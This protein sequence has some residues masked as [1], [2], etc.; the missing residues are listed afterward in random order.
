MVEG[1]Q[2]EGSTP[3]GSTTRG[4]FSPLDAVRLASFKSGMK[5]ILVALA[6]TILGA[7]ALTAMSAHAQTNVVGDVQTGM[8]V[9]EVQ[10]ALRVPLVQERDY[11]SPGART[12]AP[13]FSARKGS[14]DYHFTVS[15]LG[16]VQQIELMRHL[17]PFE[18]NPAFCR[19]AM[20]KMIAKYGRPDMGG[21]GCSAS[22]DKDAS[23]DVAFY[24]GA[25]GKMHVDY[26]DFGIERQDKL[27]S[28]APENA[29]ALSRVR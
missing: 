15:Q 18:A 6:I 27:A 24:G 3:L 9:S 8:S 17:G 4:T 10:R 13:R 21:G 14:D 28:Q 29:R 19:A 11:N 12:L 1:L 5:N 26:R 23:I 25:D 2:L 20:A 7:T 16:R 22:W